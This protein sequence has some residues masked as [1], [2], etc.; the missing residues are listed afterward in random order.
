VFK[1]IMDKYIDFYLIFF[2]FLCR[3]IL[4]RD[5]W[6]LVVKNLSRSRHFTLRSLSRKSLN[7]VIV[8]LLSRGC[9]N[10]KSVKNQ[11]IDSHRR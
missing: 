11:S 1:R 10:D 8:R 3:K 6:K 4:F 7:L 5:L 2:V 9:E